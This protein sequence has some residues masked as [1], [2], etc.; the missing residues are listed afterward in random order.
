M[1]SSINRNGLV[2]HGL[3]TEEDQN[4]KSFRER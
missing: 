2:N 4:Q 1:M 3:I